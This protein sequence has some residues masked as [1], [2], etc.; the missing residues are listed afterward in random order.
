MPR[1]PLKGV[2]KFVSPSIGSEHRMFMERLSDIEDNLI[3]K[4]GFDPMK[5]RQTAGRKE[6]NRLK[7]EARKI[8]LRGSRPSIED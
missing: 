5:F 1:N 3:R 7:Q 6:I 4:R 2:M 8:A